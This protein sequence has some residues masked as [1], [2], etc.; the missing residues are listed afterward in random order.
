MRCACQEVSGVV[1][2][3]DRG[4]HGPALFSIVWFAVNRCSSRFER[5]VRA[6]GTRHFALVDTG[7]CLVLAAPRRHPNT[8]GGIAATVNFQFCLSVFAPLRIFD[9]LKSVYSYTTL[10]ESH[11][12]GI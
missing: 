9:D 11:D 6:V 3:D 2:R 5:Q 4:F 8:D 10:R 1:F 12:K 7:T